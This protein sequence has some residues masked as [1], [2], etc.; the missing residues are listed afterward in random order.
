MIKF[1]NEILVEIGGFLNVS[2]LCELRLLAKRFSI[3]RYKV[4]L[5]VIRYRDA[6]CYITNKLHRIF[7]V[8]GIEENIYDIDGKLSIVVDVDFKD[9]NSDCVSL[10][11]SINEINIDIITY[12]RIEDDELYELPYMPNLRLLSCSN[13]G[14]KDVN[15]LTSLEYLFTSQYITDVSKLV[16]LKFLK[17]NSPYIKDVSMLLKLEWLICYQSWLGG[18]L[19]IGLEKLNKLTYLGCKNL[20]IK[21]LPHIPN[22]KY[23]NCKGTYLSD[24]SHLTELRCIECSE[25]NIQDLSGL[26]K[27]K[28]INGIK[29]R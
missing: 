1:P 26:E 22:L 29:I 21:E 12:L 25:S 5:N 2:D 24:V 13:T 16:N 19:P 15:H 7:D 11:E 28:K 18:S 8:C 27:L 6:I 20:R 17:Y 4:I 3:V 9:G 14:I 23:L 10:Y